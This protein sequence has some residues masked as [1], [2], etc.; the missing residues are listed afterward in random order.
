MHF[1]N[2]TAVYNHQKVMSATMLNVVSST[3]FLPVYQRVDLMPIMIIMGIIIAVACF[4]WHQIDKRAEGVK[5]SKRFE[6]MIAVLLYVGL[7]PVVALQFQYNLN[8][9][10]FSNAEEN[11]Q[12]KFEVANLSFTEIDYWKEDYE[13]DGQYKVRFVEDDEAKYGIVDF[14]KDTSEPNLSLIHPSDW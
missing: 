9:D 10:N 11:F 6:F 12:K 2:L 4:F 14:D 3:E 8:Q 13:V 1:V 5:L 7:T